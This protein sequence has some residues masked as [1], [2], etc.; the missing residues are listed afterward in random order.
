M[1]ETDAH[2][3]AERVLDEIRRLAELPP[4]ATPEEVFAAVERWQMIEG[5]ARNLTLPDA[6]SS[7]QKVARM[8]LGDRRTTLSGA[9]W[10]SGRVSAGQ[11]ARG[12]RW[13]DP[14]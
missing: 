1:T 12:R 2:T 5:R 3:A 9:L 8:V 14:S 4:D 10:A 11:T 13:D 7:W 6:P